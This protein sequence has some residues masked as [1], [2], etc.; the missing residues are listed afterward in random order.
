VA[1]KRPTKS[2]NAPPPRKIP[3]ATKP[4]PQFDAVGE[5]FGVNAADKAPDN[6]KLPKPKTGE[7]SSFQSPLS[8]AGLSFPFGLGAGLYMQAGGQ[9]WLTG[10]NSFGTLWST[11][12]PGTPLSFA[13]GWFGWADPNNPQPRRGGY[14][15]YRLMSLNP[16]LRLVYSVITSPILASQ[17]TICA[18][19]GIS[20]N[21]GDKPVQQD[22]RF[23]SVPKK[24][25]AI[26]SDMILPIR[27]QILTEALRYLQFGWRP[28][29]RVY[30][31][32]N[33]VA[34][35]LT[36]LKPMLPDASTII[37]GGMGNFGGLMSGG[38]RFD[39]RKAFIVSYDV[40][41]GNLYGMSRHEAAFDPWMD[42]Q[43]ARVRAAMLQAKVSGNLVVVKYRPGNT[44]IGVNAQGV[45]SDSKDNGAIAQSI[46]AT[47]FGGQGVCVPTTEYLDSDLQEHPELAK[48]A[49]W[50]VDVVQTGT[51]APAITGIIAE[52]EFQNGQMVEAWGWPK[53]SMLEA[54]R[55]GIGQGDSTQHSENA[56]TDL[57]LIDDDIA[58]QI[59]FG[60]SD[61]DVP[62]VIDEIVALNWGE[63]YRGL[64]GV[65]PAP[66][67]DSK[68]QVYTS[69]LTAMVGNPALAPAFA[70]VI[71]WPGL[72][73]H[74][75]IQTT[76][77][78]KDKLPALL[79][80][81][82]DSQKQQQD[83]KAQ[84]TKNMVEKAQNVGRGRIF[85]GDAG[86]GGGGNGAANGKPANGK[87]VASN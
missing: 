37:N 82:T 87:P 43:Y 40:E 66:L 46:I 64:I 80:Q 77:D 35:W 24:W 55:G 52:R 14:V 39:P 59:S 7:Q 9:P 22:G 38:S 65:K 50:D 1:K 62:G 25:I 81:A 29:Q 20:L 16:T 58:S 73:S 15:P 84:Q 3:F 79:Q 49:A 31:T 63:D 34:R 21:D 30:Q 74:L 78:L 51:Y 56:S 13:G 36:K 11:A 54:A 4:D 76:E 86:T 12:F 41:A 33:G 28:F 2:R 42:G 26:L 18:K 17:W 45:A 71:D 61:Y 70:S 47:L 44:P 48:L 19:E 67:V 10:F 75:D 60:L 68:V 32:K 6:A 5:Q 85:T 72:F 69:L 83:A 57:E 27:R 8:S 53:R 23:M